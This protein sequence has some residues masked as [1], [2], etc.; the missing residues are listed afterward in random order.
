M[1]QEAVAIQ[2]T[3]KRNL[4][5]AGEEVVENMSLAVEIKNVCKEKDEDITIEVLEVS[6]LSQQWALTDLIAAPNTNAALIPRERIHYVFKAKRR[7]E[8]S[9]KKPLEYSYIKVG[10]KH[11]E[12]VDDVKSP[13]YSKFLIEYLPSVDDI[14]EPNYTEPEKKRDGLIQSMLVV[15]WKAYDKIKN[16]TAIGHHCLWLDCF[17]KAL[18]QEKDLPQDIPIQL[19]DLESKT[20]LSETKEKSDKNNIVLFKLEHSNC[21]THNFTAR[22]L[23]LIPIVINLVNCYG[24]PVTV[25]IDM[26]KQQNK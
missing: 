1:F 7:I 23:C 19:D 18:S 25:F 12:S 10:K 21:V 15:R 17:A 5:R 16:K 9:G 11:P 3:P 2:V 4:S 8:E 6:L 14:T 26:S 20:N 24:V 22:K 13:P